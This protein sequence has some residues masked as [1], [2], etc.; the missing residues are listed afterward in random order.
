[1]IPRDCGPNIVFTNEK[2]IIQPLLY[3]FTN[4]QGMDMQEH[5]CTFTLRSCKSLDADVYR[6]HAT[7]E[8]V[9]LSRKKREVLAFSVSPR[10]ARNARAMTRGE[11]ACSSSPECLSIMAS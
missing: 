3:L 2:E 5:A 4:P 8:E 10:L 6:R 11:A 1:M 9:C 7:P